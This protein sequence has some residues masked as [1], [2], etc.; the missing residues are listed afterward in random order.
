[1]SGEFLV[2]RTKNMLIWYCITLRAVCT[3]RLK[4]SGIRPYLGASPG[5]IALLAWLGKIIQTWFLSNI[6]FYS[7][8]IGSPSTSQV[9][10]HLLCWSGFS[11]VL[12]ASFQCGWLSLLMLVSVQATF[13]HQF[14][15][16]IHFK[17]HYWSIIGN[18]N[19]TIKSSLS[20]ETTLNNDN[21][22]G[23]EMR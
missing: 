13:S 4:S 6:N 19:K 14:K 5:R 11:S 16:Q 17:H 21:V 20:L 1:M 2:K 10:P 15:F 7:L 18:W 23:G 12:Y 8:G 9:P 3:Q 22:E